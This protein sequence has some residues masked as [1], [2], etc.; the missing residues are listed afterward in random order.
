MIDPLQRQ[1]ILRHPALRPVLAVR[2]SKEESWPTQIG[3]GNAMRS[4]SRRYTHQQAYS[5]IGQGLASV[6][7]HAIVDSTRQV[8]GVQ[9][10]AMHKLHVRWLRPKVRVLPGH[11][12]R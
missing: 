2:I 7:D 8:Q 5:F 1:T 12:T 4:I 3:Q 6:P 9:A 10:L 11:Q